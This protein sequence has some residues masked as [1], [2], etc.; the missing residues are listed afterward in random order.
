M[1]T[2]M[3]VIQC[4]KSGL[5]RLKLKTKSLMLKQH[6]FSNLTKK[7]PEIIFIMLTE[8]EYECLT[9]IK[10]IICELAEENAPS[11][12]WFTPDEIILGDIVRIKQVLNKLL[13]SVW[14]YNYKGKAVVFCKP[15][16]KE[17]VVPSP[18]LEETV[19]GEEDE[20]LEPDLLDSV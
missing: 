12:L 5:E 15:V 10:T 1:K 20:F 7:R 9:S 2:K 13:N 6:M 14:Y 17:V 4:I 16:K 11:N 19:W 3:E 8:Y 18:E